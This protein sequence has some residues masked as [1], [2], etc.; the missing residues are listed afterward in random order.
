MSPSRP[1]VPD[2][3][4]PCAPPL[5]EE[6]EEEEEEE[7]E[8]EDANDDTAEAAKEVCQNRSVASIDPDASMVLPPPD[9]P[10]PEGSNSAHRIAPSW[11]NI[12]NE[13][14]LLLED[15]DMPDAD[16][17]LE[18]V[19]FGDC[20]KSSPCSPCPPWSPNKPVEWLASFVWEGMGGEKRGKRVEVWERVRKEK[21]LCVSLSHALTLATVGSLVHNVLYRMY[22][23]FYSVFYSVSFTVSL[24]QSP[25]ITYSY[26]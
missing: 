18:V 24:L 1:P 2:P 16:G 21:C 26:T 14:K 19:C 11:P 5:K 4:G 7:D 8:E 6:E 25:A 20:A 9:P 17:C 12:W 22:S 15:D 10:D 23:L 13:A 3:P